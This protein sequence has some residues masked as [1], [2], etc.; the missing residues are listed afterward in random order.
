MK[1]LAVD[2]KRGLVRV[3]PET[4]DDIWLLSTVIQPGDLVRAKTLRE[5]HFGD[6]GSGRS[7]RIPMVL[8][9]RVEAVEFQAF[10]TRLRIRG[11]VIEGPEK[12]G[13]VGKYHTLSIE[14][15]R[16]LDIVKPSGWPQVLIE[17]LKRGSYN[18]AAV[19]VAVDYD[20]YAVAVVR[21][22]GVKILASGGL[23]LPGKDDPT[24]EDKLR[25]A[26]TVIAKTTADVARRENALLVVAA[27]PGT[28]KN[29]V[30]EK[31]RGLVQGVKILVDNVSMGGEAG[32]F[33]EVRRGIMRQALQDA[34]VVEAE[35]ILEEFERRLAKEPGRIA[36]TLEQVYRA[37]E[38]GAVEE[39]L[40][41]DET[42]H[43]P[44]PEVRARVDE[45][46]RLADATRAKIHFVSVESPVGYKVKALGGVIALLRYAINFAGETGG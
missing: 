18:V 33:E 30:A 42:L 41:L 46:L 10:T 23:H 4:T 3:V 39:L 45:L 36:Y 27:G 15:G 31:L 7:S 14:P 32:V 43:H 40:I 5:I 26:V 24:R 1:I 25:E 22:Q 19:V 35:R 6:R 17:K 13:V 12:Y 37:A 29:L 9:V 20:D 2:T 11:I 34:A 28:V 16:E 38:M 21:G 8:T 44:D